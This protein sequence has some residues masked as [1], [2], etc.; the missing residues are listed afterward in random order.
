MKNEVA[1]TQGTSVRIPKKNSIKDWLEGETFRSQI[2]KSLPAHLPPDRFIRVALTAMTR[3]PKLAECDMASFFSCLLS[4]S[5]YG[6]EPDGRRAHL[7]PFE[8]RKRGVTECQLIID[9]KGL[10]E[11]ILRSGQ[12]SNIHSDVVCENDAFEYNCGE[13]IRHVIDFRRPRGNAYAAY[14]ICTFKDGTRKCEV[15]SQDEIESIRRRSRA[16]NAGPW[17]T[18]WNEMAKKT[19]FRRLSKWLPL[20]AEYRDA[21]ESEDE[22][23]PLKSSFDPPEATHKHSALDALAEEIDIPNVNEEGE[24][25]EEQ[26][27]YSDI[28]EPSKFED[29]PDILKLM[30]GMS[31]AKKTAM[32]ESAN[33]ENWHR[34]QFKEILKKSKASSEPKK[35]TQRP[36]F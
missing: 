2:A 13:I 18:D 23:E 6:I 12:V 29:D 8:N 17:T 10:V 30:D 16:A 9:Y 34:E 15:M 19:V 11:L 22:F 3:T 32:F 14:A 24:I 31:E 28:P 27:E 4:L 5:Q 21:L 7:I 35:P 36:V 20:S 33:N 25:I 26:G 1:P